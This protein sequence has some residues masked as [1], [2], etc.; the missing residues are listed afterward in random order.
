MYAYA[1]GHLLESFV[2]R[3]VDLSGVD[4]ERDAAGVEV[5]EVF[6]DDTRQS[7]DSGVRELCRAAALRDH[8]C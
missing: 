5:L 4:K 6:F 8:R 2:R 7:D 3:Q 1:S